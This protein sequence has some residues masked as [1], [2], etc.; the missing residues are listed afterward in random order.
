MPL[1]LRGQIAAAELAFYVPIV[2]VAFFYTVRYQ[3]EKDAGFFFLLFFALSR[4]T[5]GILIVAGEN[6]QP[7][8][9]GLF[10]AAYDLFP[11]GLALLDLAFIGFLGLAGQ[12]SYSEYSR[13]MWY[14]RI[15]GLVAVV[16]LALSIAGGIL[17]TPVNPDNDTGLLLR[18][19]AAGVYGGAWVV[20]VLLTFM[21]WS[22]RFTMRHYRRT[23]LTGVAIAL[24]PLAVRT[25]Y[26]ILQAWSS[27][28]IFGNNPSP[29]PTLARFQPV[30]GDF[31]VYL[32]MG[33]VMEYLCCLILLFSGF[34]MLRQRRRY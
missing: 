27:S 13:T 6:V 17:G 18:R 4:L 1:D 20:L 14:F 11:C 22:Y 19:I 15:G 16:A 32:V 10:I 24:L 23:L 33:L 2:A 25:A 29:N 9:V 3:F 5:Q 26:A 21:C 30:T 12:H 34:Y 7:A 28:D 31:V 8:V